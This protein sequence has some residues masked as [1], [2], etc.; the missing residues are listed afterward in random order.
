[1]LKIAISAFLCC[2][3]SMPSG[4]N[5]NR[6]ECA[7]AQKAYEE[8]YE[9][10]EREGR[11]IGLIVGLELDLEL[12]HAEALTTVEHIQKLEELNLTLGRQNVRLLSESRRD[13]KTGVLNLDG[14][15]EAYT[16][17]TNTRGRRET[18]KPDSKNSILFIDLDD[19]SGI[20]QSIGH[21][22][23]DEL[24][25]QIADSLEKS[26]RESDAV[27]RFG[28]DEF[29]IILGGSPPEIAEE[30][31]HEI[32]DTISVIN[33]SDG[34][35]VSPSASIGVITIEPGMDFKTA[36]ELA[37]SAMYEA[38]AAGRNQVF[39]VDSA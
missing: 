38:K 25:K 11:L 21:L 9:A 1:M 26:V 36:C 4:V 2:N 12:L 20:N 17:I 33:L 29:V 3:L 39:S 28:G 22:S 24:L 34:K 27:G 35:P 15:E 19:F 37:N 5:L 8:A 18:D 10:G 13:P 30:K 23:A 7:A 31:A 16:R 14:L 32:R 6:F